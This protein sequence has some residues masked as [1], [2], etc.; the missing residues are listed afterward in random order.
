[1]GSADLA[2]QASD[3]LLTD[4]KIY[5]QSINYPTVAR[6]EERLRITPTPGH[7][8]EAQ[9]QLVKALQ[10]VWN[11]L[12]LKRTNDWAAL[13]GRAG[14]GAPQPVAAVKN[15]WSDAQLGRVTGTVPGFSTFVN[16]EPYKAFHDQQ[17]TGFFESNRAVGVSA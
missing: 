7:T 16:D 6:G 1:M 17:Q 13:G 15:I 9:T 11:E 4:H 3:L 10:S 8:L 2:K 12:D 5:V 14:V